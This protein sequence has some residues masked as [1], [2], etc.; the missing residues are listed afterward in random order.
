MAGLQVALLYTTLAGQRR[1]RLHNMMVPVT[2]QFA[3]LFRL[4]ELDT[5]MNLV[6]KQGASGARPRPP[7]HTHTH[8]PRAHARTR[9]PL[10]EP[11]GC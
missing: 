3:N 4:V 9:T 2:P 5:V 7:P 1:I 8:T 11:R 6:A 10:P